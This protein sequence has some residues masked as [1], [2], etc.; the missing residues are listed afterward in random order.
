MYLVAGLGNPGREFENTRHNLGFRV[1]DDVAKRLGVP[2][3]KF[4]TKC[5]ALVGEANIVGHKVIIAEPQTFMNL[6]GQ[7]V[8]ALLSWYKIP[9]DHL[10]VIHDD[11]DIEAG[12]IRVK[13]GGGAA[14]HHGLESIIASIGSQEFIRVR[15]GIGREGSGDVTEYV[16]QMIPKEQADILN[17]SMIDAADAVVSVISDGIEAAKNKFNGRSRS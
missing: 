7:A 16:L 8:Q 2:E 1:A 10:I 15:V 9:T 3:L 17:H 13:Q 12:E 6:S 4:K 11:V 14:G 5:N